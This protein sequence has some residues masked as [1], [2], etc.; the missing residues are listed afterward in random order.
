[1]IVGFL[2]GN[3]KDLPWVEHFGNLLISL[4]LPQLMKEK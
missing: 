3:W 2:R 1:M 4:F